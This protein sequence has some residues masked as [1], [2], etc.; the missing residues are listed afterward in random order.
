[1]WR[2]VGRRSAVEGAADAGGAAVEDVGVDHGGRDILVAQELL[3]G[4][5]VVAVLE[6]VGGEA[7]AKRVWGDGLG[8]VGSS[9]GLAHGPLDQGL[10]DMVATGL[11]G[12]GVAVVAGGGEYPLP[13]PL[14]GSAGIFRPQGIRQGDPAG[15]FE[16]VDAMD[17]ADYVQVAA[18]RAGRRSGEAWCVYPCD[19]SRL[20]RGSRTCRGRD[21]S[22]AVPAPPSDA[23]RFRTGGGRPGTGCLPAARARPEP[24]PGRARQAVAPASWPG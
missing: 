6:Q 9:G 13:P 22:P 14:G 19:P 16:Q 17:L 11:A 15:A 24:P 1:M 21:P 3:D 4:A 5:D 10:V 12:S 20:G 7:V 8:D 18:Q 2:S 23:G